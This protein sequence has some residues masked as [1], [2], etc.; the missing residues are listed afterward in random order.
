MIT[1]N[2][3][4]LLFKIGRPFSG[5]Y[6]LLMRLR[7]TG[8]NQGIFKIK[9][10]PC[11][12]ISVGNITLGGTGKSPHVIA[13]CKFLKKTGLRPAVVT[14]GYG[15]KAGKGP[16]LVCDG[17]S[18]TATSKEAGDEPVMI[19]QKLK[20]PVVAGSDRYKC[21]MYA[22]NRLGAS[23]IVLDDGFQ[24]LQLH[25]DLDI[26]LMD[27]AEP[28]GN[29]YVFPG[30]NLREPLSALKRA[31]A[32]ILTKCNEVTSTDISS[33]EKHLQSLIPGRPVFKS[34]YEIDSIKPVLFPEEHSQTTGTIPSKEPVF[35]FCALAKPESFYALVKKSG[36]LI[37]GTKSFPDHYF[38]NRDDIQTVAD[39]ARKS[40]CH[41]ILTT[42]KDFA[43]IAPT[44]WNK[45]AKKMGLGVVNIKVELSA[46][47]WYFFKGRLVG[48]EYYRQPRSN[49]E[50]RSG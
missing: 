8:Y 45:Y 3:A 7:Q 33:I 50:E 14:R 28:F 16:L 25:R 41:Y 34:K 13:I 37:R 22:L 2:K 30:G 18:I 10:L 21:G 49:P 32:V 48:F 6:G 17:N 12:V 36:F 9:R 19:A 47:F 39:M 20:V 38:Y 35:C 26:V 40:G 27:V 31:D 44:T 1:E 23:V 11:P 15:G 29:G 24:H 46:S 43:K 4:Q 42:E 5:I